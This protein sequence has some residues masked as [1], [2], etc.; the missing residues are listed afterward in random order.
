M[1][2]LHLKFWLNDDA[3][4]FIKISPAKKQKLYKG[5]SSD[6]ESGSDNE[7]F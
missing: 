2:D 5:S 7:Q 4:V 1:S 3:E 6:D